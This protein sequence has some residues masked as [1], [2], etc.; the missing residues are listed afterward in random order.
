MDTTDPLSYILLSPRT[1]SKLTFLTL[2]SDYIYNQ[3]QLIKSGKKKG[4]PIEFGSLVIINGIID[5]AIQ[6]PYYPEFAVNNTYGI[7][8]YNDTVYNYAVFAD[9][10]ISGCQDQVALCRATNLT[11]LSDQALCSEATSMCRDNVEGVYYSYGGRGVYDI[12]HPYDDPTPM[13][14]FVD[15]LNLPCM[16]QKL[17]SLFCD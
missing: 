16:S 4:T 8:A 13:D 10:M 11:S 9:T 12:R 6:A 15:Y 5:E 14:T 3:T 1:L 2:Q 7:K 17:K